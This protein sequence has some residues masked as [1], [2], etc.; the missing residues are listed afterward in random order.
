P[1]YGPPAGTNQK[2]IWGLVASIFG[3]CCFPTAIAGIVL[4]LI[5]KKECEQSGQDGHGIAQ[6]AFVVGI[7]A[8][9][10]NIARFAL[11]SG[12]LGGFRYR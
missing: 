8:V 1:G 11:L 4:G 3:I 10:L 9:V 5:A 12:G 6:A 7:V 2:A